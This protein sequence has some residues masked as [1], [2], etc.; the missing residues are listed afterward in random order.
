MLLREWSRCRHGVDASDCVC[1]G[2]D[3]FAE[4]RDYG[5]LHVRFILTEVVRTRA[6]TC[7]CRGFRSIILSVAVALVLPSIKRYGVAV[8]DG[9]AALIGWSAY[10]YVGHAS[11]Y[12]LF[13]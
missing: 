12:E 1:G 6:H 13:N 4:C 2:R 9:T 10:V 3:A 7:F 11:I 8:T 5:G